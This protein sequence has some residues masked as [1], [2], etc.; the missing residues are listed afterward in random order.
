[1]NIPFIPTAGPV[2]IAIDITPAPVGPLTILLRDTTKSQHWVARRIAPSRYELTLPAED[3]AGIYRLEFDG[4]AQPQLFGVTVTVS[5]DGRQLARGERM[6]GRLGVSVQLSPSAGWG[7]SLI[8]PDQPSF[9]VPKSGP[10]PRRRQR[11]IGPTRKSHSRNPMKKAARPAARAPLRR[12][13]AKPAPAAAPAPKPARVSRPR[14]AP[15]PAT[16]VRRQPHIDFHELVRAGETNELAVRLADIIGPA[17]ADGVVG[18]PIPKGKKSVN[19]TVSLSAPGFDITPN[20]DQQ[21]KV[22]RDFDAKRERVTFRLTA[23]EP[24]ASKPVRKEIRADFKIGNRNVGGVIHWTMVV[25]TAFTGNVEGDGRSRSDAFALDEGQK[26]CDWVI[27]VEGRDESGKQ[28]FSIRVDSVLPGERYTSKRLGELTFP[29]KKLTSYMQQVFDD[30]TAQFKD[31]TDKRSVAK[32]R[33]GMLDAIE[34]LGKKLWDLLPPEFRDEYFRLRDAK[35]APKSI[36]IHSD[37][38][39]IPWEL[40]V[41]YRNGRALAPLGIAHTMARWS[42]GLGIKPADQRLAIQNGIIVNPKYAANDA[43]WWAV[44]EA[45]ELKKLLPS[46]SEIRPADAKSMHSIV[47][48]SDVQLLHYTGHGQFTARNPDLSKL[49]LEGNDTFAAISFVGATLLAKGNP[50]LYLNACGVG[51]S[52]AVLGQMGG[53]AAMCMKGGCSGIIAPYWS[54]SDDSAKKFALAFYAKIMAGSSIGKALQ[55]LRASKRNDPTFQAFAYF[56]DPWTR[57]RFEDKKPKRVG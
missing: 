42:P 51:S 32:W 39:V 21:L 54:V 46:L 45:Q 38:M 22:G 31:L 13:A 53:F 49:V 4:L 52:G 17:D 20:R 34:T 14:V 18:V 11:H 19:V 28:P 7:G 8:E 40:V 29:V 35:N 57:A 44:I 55:E 16:E 26:D 23:R 5:Q 27:R 36:Q 48:R 15:L 12:S 30:F 43:L 10:Q 33:K 6:G 25:P 2:S 1:M 9:S 24:N 37:E 47:K 50:V 3:A 56:G 41:P